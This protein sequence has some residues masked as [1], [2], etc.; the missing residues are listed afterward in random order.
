MQVFTAGTPP[1]FLPANSH[2]GKLPSQ[3]PSAAL[4]SQICFGH[5]LR[6][7]RDSLLAW[8]RHARCVTSEL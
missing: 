2:A 7:R 1:R 5:S 3:F 4:P 6:P 8:R